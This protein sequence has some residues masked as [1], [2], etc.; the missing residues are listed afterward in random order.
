[1]V[2]R[3]WKD[4][5]GA[6]IVTSLD[7]FGRTGTP[8]SHPDLLDWLAREFVRQ[9]WSLK[10]IDRLMM[11]SST[12]RQASLVTPVHEARDPDNRL[13]S[14]MPMRRIDAEELRDTLL[15][16]SGRLDE[17]R[18]GRPDPVEVRKDGLVT[19]K[20]TEKG[21]RRS[22]YVQQRRTEVP[23]ILEA[24]DLPQMN[25][26]CVERTESTVASQA[27]LLMNNRMVHGL[28][29]AFAERVIAEG[30][31]DPGPQIDRVY[32]LALSRPPSDDERGWSLEALSQL[33]DQWA[34]QLESEKENQE[35]LA[36]QRA[37]AAVCHTVLNSAAFL[38]ID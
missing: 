22:I 9:G 19:S 2:N 21:W 13:L 12:Y 36:A 26:N 18:F 32:R 7:N 1:M 28:A 3:V 25:P 38:Y 24:F 11:T 33:T 16:V 27:L 34:A 5:F 14:R 8:P 20:G 37:L 35:G 17:T 6:G 30:F 10:A 15:V 23:T 31:A 4:H 29:D